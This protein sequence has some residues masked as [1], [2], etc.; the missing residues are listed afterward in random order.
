MHISGTGAESRP[1]IRYDSV[2]HHCRVPVGR[3]GCRRAG[4][5]FVGRISLG[6]Q[7]GARYSSRWAR[8]AR[9]ARA[10]YASLGAKPTLCGTVESSTGTN[11]AYSIRAKFYCGSSS[12]WV[13]AEETTL[14]SQISLVVPA[15]SWS[16]RAT[17]ARRT[18]AAVTRPNE[19]KQQ[20]RTRM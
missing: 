6:L 11:R 19:E 20:L 3:V 10:K 4:L 8:G 15:S 13:S 16:G 12:P 9:S 17:S 7:T 5:D 14:A 1:I 2:G 18:P